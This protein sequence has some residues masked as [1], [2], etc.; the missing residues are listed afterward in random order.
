MTKSNSIQSFP[1]CKEIWDAAF[2]APSGSILVEL[3]DSGVAMTISDQATLI[4]DLLHYRVLVR[5]DN[6]KFYPEGHPQHMTSIFDPFL[7]QKV[8]VDGK[9]F[10]RIRRRR[11]DQFKIVDE[12]VE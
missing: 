3:A 8:M 7:V 1:H 6:S 11:A 4:G 9:L 5:K 12:A 2:A 10:V